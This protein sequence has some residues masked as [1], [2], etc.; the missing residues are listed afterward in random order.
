L[1]SKVGSFPASAEVGVL[2]DL[3]AAERAQL[4]VPRRE[5]IAKAIELA[6]QGDTSAFR[7]CMDRLVPPR[8]DRP[9][10]LDLPPVHNA[11]DISEAMTRIIAAIADG[12]ITPNEGAVMANLLSVQT[13]VLSAADLERRVE[14]LEQ[15]SS[16]KGD[17]P[18]S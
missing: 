10:N 15:I 9:I 3:A 12:Q 16:A 14:L 18:R 5:P 7:L 4:E 17:E 8:K 13:R 11:Q 6:L 1:A 2:C